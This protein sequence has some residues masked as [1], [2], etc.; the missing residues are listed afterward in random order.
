MDGSHRNGKIDQFRVFKYEI[1]T[2]VSIYYCSQKEGNRELFLTSSL[3]KSYKN[4]GMIS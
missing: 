2:G 4:F 1:D 3:V